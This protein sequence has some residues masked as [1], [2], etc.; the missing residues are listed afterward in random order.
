MFDEWYALDKVMGCLLEPGSPDLGHCL[1]QRCTKFKQPRRSN[2]SQRFMI[3]GSGQNR[4]CRIIGNLSSEGTQLTA[5]GYDANRRGVA[6]LRLWI[7]G[8]G[9]THVWTTLLTLLWWHAKVG[10]LSKPETEDTGPEDTM[11]S[12]A[13]KRLHA[14]LWPLCTDSDLGLIFC[15]CNNHCGRRH[16]FK[17]HSSMFL[18]DCRSEPALSA[19]KPLFI[20]ATDRH[21][22]N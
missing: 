8:E 17:S 14:I 10:M 12:G 4:P 13:F 18:S 22:P 7:T 2:K 20:G 9:V 3:P 21:H 15:C 11:S 6:S 5:K 1:E 19:R 16:C